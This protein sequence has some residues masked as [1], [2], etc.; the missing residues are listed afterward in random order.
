PPGFG[1][2]KSRMIMTPSHAK[3]L[4][5]VLQENLAEYEKRFGEIRLNHSKVN[6]G[7]IQ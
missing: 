6:L 4:L 5:G 3:R 1:K 2:L 7:S